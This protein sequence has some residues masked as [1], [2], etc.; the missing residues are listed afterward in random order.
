MRPESCCVLRCATRLG[1]LLV[2]ALRDVFVGSLGI[3]LGKTSHEPWQ[4]GDQVPEET[5]TPIT[6]LASSQLGGRPCW[7]SA[8]SPKGC[9]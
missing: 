2:K 1:Q 3:L 4:E 9:P 5:P 8:G 6:E 7:A